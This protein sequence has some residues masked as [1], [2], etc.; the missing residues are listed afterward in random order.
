M[1]LNN[2]LSEPSEWSPIVPDRRHS[3]PSSTQASAGP[4]S[5]EASSTSALQTLV[6]NLRNHDTEM[7]ENA[8]SSS[9]AGLLHELRVR[10]DTLSYSL[11]ESD[12]ALAK[13]LVSLLSDLNR[14]SELGS[15]SGLHPHPA[16]I[17]PTTLDAP[18]P[19]D[20]FDTLTRQLSD[21]QISRLSSQAEVPSSNTPPRLAVE[22]TL[23][24]SRI[25]AE[26][27][28]VVALC[29]QRTETIPRFV[30]DHLPPQYDRED[31]EEEPLP[32]YDG[33]GRPS[34]DD[35]KAKLASPLLV[36]ASR[37]TDEKMRLDLEAVALAIDRLYLVAPQLH[38]QRVE[39]KS[40]K[41]A[42]MEK[43]SREGTSSPRHV[44]RKGKERD[45][46]EL[47]NMLELIGK[48]S[49]RT[50]KDQSVILDGGMQSRLEKARKKD[51]AKV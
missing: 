22:V 51:S 48:A 8:N 2:L 39:L 45:V 7:I 34:L 18:P 4:S 19:I 28:N 43:A 3:M 46:R 24:W 23:L 33:T 30:N 27:E 11:S 16:V 41:K 47:E 38:N 31:Y 20:V 50:L 10:V 35:T 6:T 21:L 17:E 12:A 14:L 29:K 15:T 5:T 40:A 13:A 25:D 44:S 1:T 49:E 32:D 37:V 42:Q 26:L 9:D 36:S